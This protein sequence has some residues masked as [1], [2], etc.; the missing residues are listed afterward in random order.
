MDEAAFEH[1]I[2]DE[3]DVVVLFNRSDTLSERAASNLVEF[4]ESGRGLVV[5]HSGLS[6]YNGWDWWWRD[7]VGGKYQYAG[8]GNTPASGFS[9][10]ERIEFQVVSD[11][12]IT[13]AIGAFAMTDE[14]YSGL[15]ISRDARILYRT[16]N[17]NS[18]GPLVWIGPHQRSRVIVIQPGHDASAYGNE[19][20]RA[21]IRECINGSGRFSGVPEGPH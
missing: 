14:L 6:S 20:F 4:V 3:Y 7:V 10:G 19:E 17:P 8:V 1:D 21:L 16:E 12:P 18:D 15:G 11:H 13:E 5:L 9:Q 2:K